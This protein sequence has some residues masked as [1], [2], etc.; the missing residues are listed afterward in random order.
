MDSLGVA[1]TN[2]KLFDEIIGALLS[3]FDHFSIDRSS[4][5]QARLDLVHRHRTSLFPWRGQ[6]SPELIELIL[7]EYARSDSV[8]ADPFVGSGTTLFEA[9]RKSLSCLGGE[10]NPAAVMMSRTVHFVNLKPLE[11]E[12]HIRAAQAIIEKRL[13]IHYIGGLFSSLEGQTKDNPP[14]ME[15]SLKAMLRDASRESL[16]YDIIANAIIRLVMKSYP[17]PRKHRDIEG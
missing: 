17:N 5:P 4:T 12:S 13:P 15:D 2:D 10:I 6:F 3:E 11:R 16:V 14:P 7:T 9:A 1:V 8:V